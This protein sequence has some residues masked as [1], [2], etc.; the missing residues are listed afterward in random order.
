MMRKRTEAFTL[1]ELL[2]VI[3]IIAILAAILLPTVQRVRESAKTAKCVSNLRQ[4]GLATINFEMEQGHLPYGI[5][6]DSR[7]WWYHLK[8]YTGAPDD[9]ESSTFSPVIECPSNQIPT[10]RDTPAPTYAA[11]RQVF[12][13]GSPQ[14][15]DARPI[16]VETIPRPTEVLLLADS[17]QRSAGSSNTTLNLFPQAAYPAMADVPLPVT[18]DVDGNG[19]GTSIRYR[20][21]ESANVVFADGHVETARKGTLLQRH[22]YISY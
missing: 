15:S 18:G 10:L 3:A 20:H 8:E 5:F 14:H 9:S 17:T 16:T 19:S 4:L 11:N 1:I 13:V 21:S 2:T 22:L 7:P 12:V 6:P